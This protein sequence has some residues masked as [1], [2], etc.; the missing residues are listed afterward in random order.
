MWTNNVLLWNGPYKTYI[1]EIWNEIK[2]LFGNEIVFENVICG[3]VAIL[4]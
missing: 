1:S 3:I 2:N 4:F